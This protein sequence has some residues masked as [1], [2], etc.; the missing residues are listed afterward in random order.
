M[1]DEQPNKTHYL[2]RVP[3]ETVLAPTA[4]LVKWLQD[5]DTHPTCM[6]V[7]KTIGNVADWKPQVMLSKLRGISELTSVAF[8]VL[9]EKPD[10]IVICG[11]SSIET[12][13]LEKEPS[14]NG[15]GSSSRCRV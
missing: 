14:A 10:R 8:S 1:S 2:L 4:A 12:T 13:K 5:I 9:L 11:R 6:L 3:L 7:Q 15:S